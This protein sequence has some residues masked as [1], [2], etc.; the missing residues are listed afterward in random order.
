MCL[1]I[2]AIFSV[3]LDTSE[4]FNLSQKETL[5][6][7]AYDAYSPNILL[8]FVTVSYKCWLNLDQIL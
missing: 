2:W 3:N 6:N 5:K 7:Y 4:V 1:A 8:A